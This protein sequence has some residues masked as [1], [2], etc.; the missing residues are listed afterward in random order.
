MP[1]ERLNPVLKRVK[2]SATLVINELS[3]SLIKEGKDIYKLGFGQSP[4]PVPE[5]IT[6]TLRQNAYQK[7]YMPT[8]GLEILRQEAADFFRRNYLLS[9]EKEDIMVG[10]GSKELLYDFQLAYD[11]EELLLPTPSWVSYEPQAQLTNRKVVWLPT[12]EKKDYKITSDTIIDHC[13]KDPDVT[14][15]L[16]LNYPS[17]PLGITY[18]KEELIALSKIFRKYNIVV[19]ADEIYGEIHH[20]GNHTTIA[21][22]YPEGTIISTGLSKWAGAGGWRF[23]IFVFP[24]EFRYILDAMAIIASET[25]TSVSAPIQYAAVEAYRGGESIETYLENSRK[26]LKVVADFVYNDLVS[27]GITMPKP[28]GGFYLLPNFGRF[29]DALNKKAMYTSPDLCNA[30]LKE[31]G[32]A[33][34][35]GEA[36][37]LPKEHLSARLSYVDFDGGRLLDLVKEN[38]KLNLD[39]NFVKTYCPKIIGATQKIKSWLQE[40]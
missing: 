3:Q 5:K 12:Q 18:S 40:L 4:F 7:D 36:F 38:P 28:Q 23:G 24:K 22:Y 20:E 11:F 31:T 15:V 19:I 37:G 29:K 2:P 25:F 35:P 17:N 30:L 33:L 9:T 32:V 27:I 6:S 10:P 34:L 26:I 14:R 16:I 13:K 1:I 21:N 39:D 8:K